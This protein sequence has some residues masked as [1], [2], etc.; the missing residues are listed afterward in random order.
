MSCLLI[1]FADGTES[2][3]DA[4]RRLKEQ[5]SICEIF[6]KVVVT[7]KSE[8]IQSNQVSQE[9]LDFMNVRNRGFG[10]WV[11]KPIILQLALEG[12]WGK[13]DFT[14]YLDAGC[15]YVDNYFSR[16]RMQLFFNETEKQGFKAFTTPYSEFNYS[17]QRVLSLLEVEEK[18]F[19]P[20]IE[21]T[22]VF[23]KNCQ[24]SS[25]FIAKW[26]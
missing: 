14:V 2:M 5:T 8:L 26:L 18:R 10:Y 19:S 23:I 11:R 20:Q 7:N 21:A 24:F 22:T 9:I 4:G 6:T 3:I 25:D 17:K 13:F 12:Y 15:E 1:C 16:L